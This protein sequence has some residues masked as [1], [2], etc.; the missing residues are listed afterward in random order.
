M[1]VGG[2]N[3]CHW[4]LFTDMQTPYEARRIPYPKLVYLFI[5]SVVCRFKTVHCILYPFTSWCPWALHGRRRLPN[6]HGTRLVIL[7]D[8]LLLSWV[9]SE[10]R[11]NWWISFDGINCDTRT[12]ESDRDWTVHLLNL[13]SSDQM[14]TLTMNYEQTDCYMKKMTSCIFTAECFCE[15]LKTTQHLKRFSDVLL[16]K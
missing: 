14:D 13:I 2:Q 16:T 12:G 7:L 10:C 4:P 3:L 1:F 8:E 11:E 6:T 9:S 5:T 15:A